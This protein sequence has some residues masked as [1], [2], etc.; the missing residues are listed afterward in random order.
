MKKMITA[1]AFFA[2]SVLG[3]AGFATAVSQESLPELE[4]V[5]IERAT[6]DVDV[7]LEAVEGYLNGINTMRAGFVQIAPDG[8]VSEGVFHLERPGRVRFEY[9][10][11]NPVLIVS[12]GNILNFIDYEIGQITRW[13]VKDTPLALLLDRTIAFGENVEVAGMN[14]GSLA[15][16]TTVTTYDPE[17]PEQGMLT[18]IFERGEGEALNLFA[19]E[20]VDAQ[21]ALTQIRI[22]NA[23]FNLSLDKKLWEFDDPRGKRFD[24]RRKR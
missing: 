24:R 14:P 11:D 18:L 21:G 8:S 12:D 17:K 20:V 6:Y 16:L 5:E 23:E 7:T 19:W 15:N 2:A 1:T 9:G 13:P 4:T 3:L 22:S 10:E